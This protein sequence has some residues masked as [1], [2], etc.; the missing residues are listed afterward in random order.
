MNILLD[1]T[2]KQLSNAL[3]C[4][5]ILEPT[6]QSFLAAPIH[7]TVPLGILFM[8]DHHQHHVLNQ[9]RSI[10]ALFFIVMLV[11]PLAYPF[12]CI[13]PPDFLYKDCLQI[14]PKR[15]IVI[16]QLSETLSIMDLDNQTL[17]NDC[18]PTDRVPNQ[19]VLHNKQLYLLHSQGN[20]LLVL[21]EKNFTMINEIKIPTGKDGTGPN[22]WAIQFLSDQSPLAV[23][24]NFITNDLSLIDTQTGEEVNR[25]SLIDPKRSL[26]TPPQYPRP[27]GITVLESNIYVA[28]TYYNFETGLFDPGEVV[29]LES[30]TLAILKRIPT[31]RNP[32]NLVPLSE[33]GE[34]HVICTG[35]NDG[36]SANEDGIIDI[37]DINTLTIQK[38]I[39][40]GGSPSQWSIADSQNT[41]YLGNI[42]QITAYNHQTG[43]PLFP[44][45]N[46][47][48]KVADEQNL[49]SGIQVY[50]T[51]L[52]ISNYAKDTLYAINLLDNSIKAEWITGDGPIDLYYYEIGGN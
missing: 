45:S 48:F 15:L 33:K 51:Q 4:I 37:I 44:H 3:I 7:S 46:P 8:R 41:I 1:Q 14:G 21:D 12:Y 32:Q 23:I 11:L 35:Y 5:E 17:N 2:Y 22:P 20:N 25:V 27:E 34:V 18:V 43:T 13:Q 39:P 16:N 24:S 26:L 10:G 28:C 36:M 49:L 31:H 29:V 9:N 6:I 52:Y 30:Q 50:E 42:G 40:I 38:S 19:I 47:L